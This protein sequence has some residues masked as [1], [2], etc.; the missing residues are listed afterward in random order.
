MK[1]LILIR[2]VWDHNNERALLD[3]ERP[4]AEIIEN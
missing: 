1:F 4:I 3:F 2:L